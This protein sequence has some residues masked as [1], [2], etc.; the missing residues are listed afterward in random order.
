MEITWLGHS[1]FRIKGKE[2]IVLTDPCGKETGYTLHKQHAD[3]VTVSHYHAGHSNIEAIEGDF[4]QI[5]GPGEYEL[6]NVFITGYATYHDATEGQ[7]RG[8][9][10][11]YIIEIE[12]VTICHLGDLGH[13]IDSSMEE[14]IGDVGVLFVPVGGVSTIDSS[15]AAEIV[16]SIAPRIV[17]PMHYK[18]PATTRDLEPV[19][20]F[21]KKSG[22]KEPQPQARLNINKTNLPLNTEVIV[23]NY[24]G[25]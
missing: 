25:A 16:R 14:E 1:C 2:A 20:N 12:G 21:L 19:E 22:A 10:T 3:I 18:T 13:A 11:V 7:E 15:K 6:K 9:N 5:K 4:R 23:L 24:P 17:I 8:K